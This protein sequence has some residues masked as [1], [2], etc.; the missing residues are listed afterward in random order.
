AAGE[1]MATDI[2]SPIQTESAAAPPKAIAPAL[3]TL[4]LIAAVLAVSFLGSGRMAANAARPHGRLILYL[5]TMAMQWAIVGYIWM[6]IKR[7]GVRVREVI[8][9][10]WKSS[11]DVDFDLAIAVGF[12]LTWSF[13]VV[14]ASIALGQAKL[15]PAHSLSR[16]NEVKK[17]LGFIV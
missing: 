9:G 5:G 8:G 1:K 17:N 4:G 14:V 10:K 2:I 16:A 11:D 3:H 6:G 7:R 15:D 12:W 13:F